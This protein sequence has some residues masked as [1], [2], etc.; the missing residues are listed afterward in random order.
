M[1]RIV[2]DASLSKILP[3]IPDA[4][5]LCDADGNVIGVYTPDPSHFENL[6]PEM[7]EEELCRREAEPGGR[8]LAAIMADLEKRG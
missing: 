6:E 5:E 3:N 1:R 7:S 8:S 2:V 4:V